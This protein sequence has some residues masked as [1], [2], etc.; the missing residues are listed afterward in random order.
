VSL[1]GCRKQS[2]TLV[3]TAIDRNSKEKMSTNT[4]QGNH[5]A[6]KQEGLAKLKMPGTETEIELP[7]LLDAF[8]N[9]FIDIQ[10]LQPKYGICTYDPGFGST[11]SC[12]SAITYIDGLQGRLLYRGYPIEDIAQHG[13]FYDA[14][15]LIL[16]G[17][18]PSA[19]EKRLFAREITRHTLINEKFIE[20]LR[21]FHHDAAP[22][23]IMC[24][25]IGAMSAFY[26][27]MSQVKNPDQQIRACYRLIA[28]M[29]TLAAMSYKMHMGEPIVYPRND[30]NFC[31]NFLYM[32]FS[33]PTEKYQVDETKARALEVLLILHL[34]HEQ[35]AST[36]TVRTAGS[37]QA[38]PF[39]CIASGIAALWG[40]AHGGAN[41]AVLRMLEEI[42]AM[43]GKEK[44][45]EIV[46]RAK[47]KQSNIRLMGFGHRVYKTYDPRAKIMKEITEDLLRILNKQDP[48][49][50]VAMELEKIALE[51]EY[52]VSRNLYPNVDFYSGIVL[53]ALEIPVEMYTVLFAMARTVGWVSQWREMQMEK[54]NRISRP[55]QIYTG[56]RERKFSALAS[57]P[58][59]GKFKCVD[60]EEEPSK[61]KTSAPSVPVLSRM[62]STHARINR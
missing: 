14:S 23:A 10:S 8:G 39:A 45:P 4:K 42:Q 18:L 41:E 29:P 60:N 35:N 53:R 36:S 17:E 16:H 13:D 52:F 49:L 9:R 50:E 19:D 22:M 30:L 43:G 61:E 38:N 47:D 59:S 12:E 28:K 32:M 34:D 48:L 44:I 11:A 51:D 55:R 5:A 58:R 40:P 26:P 46:N 2:R 20:F 31:E 57:R 25:C 1:E 62:L 21:G 54:S 6:P 7:V 33:L 37:S 3:G 15:Y 56:S 27:E 24:G